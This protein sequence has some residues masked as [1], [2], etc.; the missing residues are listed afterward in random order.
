MTA[1]N[2]ANDAVPTL[3]EHLLTD[4]F[5]EPYRVK[6]DGESQWEQCPDCARG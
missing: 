4:L 3:L 5:G 2:T 6:G 1:P